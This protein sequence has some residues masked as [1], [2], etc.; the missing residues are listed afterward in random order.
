[1][2]KQVTLEEWLDNNQLG[3]DIWR[4]KY[5]NNNES[6]DSW[7][8]RV[9]GG[10]QD[11]RNLILEKKFL[12]GGRI[13]ANRNVKSPGVTYSNCYVLSVKDSIEDIY[14]CCSE[15]ARTFSYG[16]GVGIDISNLRP[17]GAHVNNSAKETT[18][19]VSFMKTF[20][21]VTETIG[22]HGRRGA[23][24]VSI[25]INHPDVVDFINI[26]ANTDSITHAN[27]SVRVNDE[28]M[29]AVEL[30]K[31][32]I[33]KWPCD[34]PEIFKHPELFDYNVL[35]KQTDML[36][37]N[38]VTYFK[39]IKARE[40]FMQ[41]AR[42]NWDYA[43][44]GVLYWDRISKW[45]MMS[46][47]PGFEYAGVNPCA[48]EPLPDGGACLLGS[49]NISKYVVNGKFQTVQ[50]WNDV[51]IATRALNE[52]LEEG[53]NLHPLKVQREA[54]AKYHQIGLG[55]FDLGGALIKLGIRYGSDKAKSF[56]EHVTREMLLSAFKTSCDINYS[57][58]KPV[59]YPGLF[60]SKFYKEQIEPYLDKDYLGKYPYN[61]QLLT[62]A[63]TGT[64]STMVDAASGGGEPMFALEYF[65]TTKSLHDKDVTYKVYP[66][67]VREY[68]G[69]EE[70]DLTKLP[71]FFITS[72][73]IDWKDRIEMQGALQQYIDASISSTVN[74]PENTT[75]NDVFNLY[76][77]AWKQELKGVTIFRNNCKRVAILSTTNTPESKPTEVIKRPKQLEATCYTLKASGENF[78]VMVGTY[79][80]KPYEVFCQRLNNNEKTGKTYK[81][82]LVKNKK[83]DYSFISDEFVIEHIGE[84]VLNNEE[85]ATTLYISMLLRH[86]ADIKYIIKT[87]RKVDNTIVSFT[88]A[89]CRV[90]SKYIPEGSSGERCPECGGE[91]TMDG[92][93]R[94]CQSC[95][96]SACL[97]LKRG[98][99][100]DED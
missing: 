21:T 68:F 46:E 96:Y 48:E 49:M 27:I 1:M 65:R 4:K 40:L 51:Q 64:I 82:I 20:D 42:N 15:M 78:A 8:D 17:K 7:L 38:S 77:Y 83:M 92:G 72:E 100:V 76:M 3:I 70:P 45:H 67:I 23:L 73:N 60:E 25:D 87:A 26:K 34:S 14:K 88:A 47:N 6:F 90:L 13:I 91:L 37:P 36:T 56:A 97:F 10:N 18:G 54:A 33:L 86:N 5:Q 95:G 57:K 24:M 80:G 63:P 61:S 12:F 84:N 31:D 71:N 44:P 81:G 30:D 55:L 66:K 69:D 39:K 9:S 32:Y 94:H 19:A 29:K 75:V 50:F 16:G 74:L 53:M 11:V 79:D 28:F 59:E 58:E 85:R 98:D 2:A 99:S 35:V 43:E 93:C 22:Q 62:I 89:I 41:I 52:V